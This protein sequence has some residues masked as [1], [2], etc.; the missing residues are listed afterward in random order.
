MERNSFE[1]IQRG[2]KLSVQ[3]TEQIEHII[4]SGEIHPG[5]KLPP[6]R[7]LCQQF[8]VSRTVI[9][10]AVRV[11]EAKGLLTSKGGSGTY[12][13]ALEPE[14]VSSSLGM[15]L[16]TQSHSISHDDLME[17]RRVLEVKVAAFA[18]ERAQPDSI[19]ELRDLL[20]KM[21]SVVGDSDAFAQ[22]DLEFHVTLARATGNEIFALL[23]DPFIDVLYEARRMASKLEGVPEEA[24]E[25]HRKIL[26]RVEARDPDGAAEAMAMHIEQAHR[27]TKKAILANSPSADTV[28]D[29][30]DSAE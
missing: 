18:A 22:Y 9:R 21:E 2:E 10:E 24:I 7:E 4:L 27:V 17:V 6:E 25:F 11:L 23:L 16:S 12:V 19:D 29:I 15:Y 13:R 14:D 26:E 28:L 1:Q 8:G 5:E 30:K 3:V 20:S